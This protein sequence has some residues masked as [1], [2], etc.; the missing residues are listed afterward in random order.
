[1][2]GF[3]TVFQTCA[4]V[5]AAGTSNTLGGHSEVP[6]SLCEVISRDLP[7]NCAC[8]E[9]PLGGI[10]T[11]QITTIFNDPIELR[12]DILP[13]DPVAHMDLVL[14]DGRFHK[15]VTVVT[16]EL[17]ESETF[18]VPGISLAIPHVG[19]VGVHVVGRLD[20]SL[21]NMLVEIGFDACLKIASHEVCGASLTR[22]LPLWI[23]KKEFV[24]GNLCNEN[25]G[26][27]PSVVV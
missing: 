18:P 14:T 23:L 17:G 20:G 15:N 10:V 25:R 16:V 9:R 19:S 4:F 26:I 8:T 22:Y 6:E 27:L 24:F 21:Q 11:C 3:A 1:M 5:A 13:C 2:R 7:S 12:A